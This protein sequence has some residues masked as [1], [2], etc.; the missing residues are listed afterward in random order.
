[1]DEPKIQRQVSLYNTEEEKT[2]AENSRRPGE[3]RGR[4]GSDAAIN[5]ECLEPR[6][7]EE[8]RRD[9]LPRDWTERCPADK[10][11]SGF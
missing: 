9:S 11:I 2:Q 4:D 10:L 6:K 5:Q 3:D 7:L 8:A 1:M